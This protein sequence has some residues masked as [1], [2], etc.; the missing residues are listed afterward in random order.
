MPIWKLTP[1]DLF[2]GT[3]GSSSHKG[4][5]TVR[6]PSEDIARSIAA[7]TLGGA[8]MVVFGQMI[9]EQPWRNPMHVRAE[10]VDGSQWS[11]DGPILVL[12]PPGY[13]D[14][15]TNVIF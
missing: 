12:D 4:G 1:I 2:D 14:D 8:Q 3:W 7:I 13:E 6:A 5:A 10:R 15:Y 9:A 11:E